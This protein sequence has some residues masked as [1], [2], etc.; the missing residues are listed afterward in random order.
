MKTL[1]KD[2][3]NIFQYNI[4]DTTNPWDGVRGKFCYFQKNTD[5]II[6]K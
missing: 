5:V 1:S 4:L 3:E 6:R 2:I